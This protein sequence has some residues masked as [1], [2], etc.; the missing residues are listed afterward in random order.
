MLSIQDVKYDCLYFRGTVPCKPNKLY[1]EVCSTCRFYQ[2]IEKR[3]LI[4]KLG[5]LGDVIRT[6]PLV[7]SFRKMYP[8]CHITWVT[9]SPE[10]LPKTQINEIYKLDAV[11]LFLLP[12]LS[13][14]I[15]I[16]LDKEPEACALL[17]QVKATQKFGFSWNGKHIVPANQNAEHKLMTGFFDNI[18]KTNTKS[19]LQEIFEICGLEFQYEE[20]LLDVEE[21][22]EQKWKTILREKA[23]GKKIIGLNTGCG[24]RWL[25]RLWPEEYWIELIQKLQQSGYFPVVL[26]GKDEEPK[27]LMYVQRTGVYYPGTY[28]IPEFI[29]INQNCDGIVSAVSMAMHIAV[30]LKK[31][32]ILFNNIF[33][34]HEF[35]LYGRGEI[36]EP[37]VGCD[38][39]Y[40]NTCKR[41]EHCMKYL[42]VQTV[43]EAILRHIPL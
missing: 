41:E 30:G 24:A 36:V 3:I 42:S 10:I 5:A 12:Q 19:Y 38:C 35:E 18:S 8:Y 25:T 28:S 40:G 2:P 29:A 17:A 21:H 15:A 31:P 33:N 27:N 11:S 9:L 23:N 7:A 6:T 34:K 43:Y 1:N 39:F 37:S 32:L 16:N 22:F 14:D 4:I 26:G 20:Y 13:F